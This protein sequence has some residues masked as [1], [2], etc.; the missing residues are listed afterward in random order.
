METTDSDGLYMKSR[1]SEF[2]KA[3]SVGISLLWKCGGNRRLYHMRSD[4][5]ALTSTTIED[6]CIQTLRRAW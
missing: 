3:S 1:S 5:H 4:G 6:G 2:N